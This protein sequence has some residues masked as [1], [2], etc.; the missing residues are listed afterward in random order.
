METTVRPWGNFK[1]IGNDNNLLIK[2]ITVNPN[3]RFSLQYHNSRS[4]F[5]YVTKGFGYVELGDTV[6][7]LD[8]VPMFVGS[9]VKIERT[10]I[11]R[12]TAGPD[13]ITFIEI[14]QGNIL[15]E[16]DIVRIE[17]DFGRK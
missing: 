8:K 5:W 10:Q 16:E 7:K 11:H 9:T 15:S 17:D 14:Q 13:G 4:E 2:S 1:I 6:E 3:S 12:M